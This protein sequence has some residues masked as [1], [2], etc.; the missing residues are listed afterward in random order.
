MDERADAK[1]TARTEGFSDG[2][3]SIAITLLILDLTVPRLH[4][5]T[6]QDLAL[7]LHA[8]LY[9]L[10]V[11]ALSFATIFIMWVNHHRIFIRLHH[12]DGRIM[13]TNGLLL[14]LV[15]VCP[16]PTALAAEYLGQPAGN[17]AAAVYAGYFVVVNVSFNL[18]LESAVRAR[19]A[20]QHGLDEALVR[21]LR[22]NMR[23]GFVAY[24]V[25]AV[26]AIWSAWVCLGICA[27]LWFY[28]ARDLFQATP[29]TPVATT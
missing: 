10:A 2:V 25:A 27:L 28:W 5:A 14:L 1:D 26:S 23:F 17:V 4:G 6:P 3:F 16:F 29:T 20:T 9:P 22:R 15:T 13:A 8:E 7:A 24:V 11:L 21:R 12:I 18:L 19:H